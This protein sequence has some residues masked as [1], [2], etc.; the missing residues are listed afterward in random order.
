MSYVEFLSRQS[1]NGT[2][3]SYNVIEIIVHDRE[4]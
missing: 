4:W 2:M 3:S 1:D